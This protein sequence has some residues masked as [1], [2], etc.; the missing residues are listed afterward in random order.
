M[1]R[2]ITF[3]Y[4][5]FLCIAGCRKEDEEPLQNDYRVVKKLEY[6]NRA[7]QE[8]YGITEY[9]YD[10][11]SN[12]MPTALP[13]SKN[14]TLYTY[15]NFKGNRPHSVYFYSNYGNGLVLSHYTYYFY[16]QQKTLRTETYQSDGILTSA[17]HFEYEGDDVVGIVT[18]DKQSG[19]IYNDRFAYDNQNRMIRQERYYQGESLMNYITY[20]YDNRGRQI[21]RATYDENDQLTGRVEYK[22]LGQQIG[23]IEE[24]TYW[25]GKVVTRR[26][27]TYDAL[28][29]QVACIEST[30][31]GGSECTVLQRKYDG[32]RILEEIQAARNLDCAEFNFTR[33][34]YEEF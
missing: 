25:S 23:P 15:F 31:S 19:I 6:Q 28:G 27:W 21:E 8:P 5:V 4:I 18:T 33:Y 10:T 11:N 17:T 13:Q 9:T 29:N 34:E 2:I 16:N 32:H 30:D 7:T 3:T 24:L 1:K 26:K 20:R 12:D 14:I 22:Y